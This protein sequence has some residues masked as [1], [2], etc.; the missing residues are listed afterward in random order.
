MPTYH[1]VNLIGWSQI[2]DN[3]NTDD[4][5]FCDSIT[6]QLYLKIMCGLSV[7]KVSGVHF[8][9]YVCKRD[10]S[11]YLLGSGI[12]ADNCYI[13]PHFSENDIHL[14]ES[15][16]T[17]LLKQ[18]SDVIF[19]GISSPKQNILAKHISIEFPNLH[20][21]CL[22]AALYEEEKYHFLFERLHLNWLFF[23]LLQPRRFFFKIYCTL[24]EVYKLSFSPGSRR[25]LEILARRMQCGSKR[26]QSANISKGVLK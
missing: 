12:A 26:F 20:V 13:L 23:L 8:Y 21:F 10:D 9:K 3:L 11:T 5:V 18:T 24:F 22:G 25:K 4:I 7:P 15:L 16:R 17:F 6:L 1:F 2:F 19:L 14:D